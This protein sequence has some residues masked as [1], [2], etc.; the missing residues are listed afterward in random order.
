MVRYFERGAL[1]VLHLSA[2]PAGLPLDGPV[3]RAQARRLATIAIR[4][5]HRHTPALLLLTGGDTATEVLRGLKIANLRVV[6]E[7]LPGIPLTIAQAG[8]IHGMPVILK[9]GG[10]GDD[11]VLL[12]LVRLARV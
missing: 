2:P 3:A 10:F 6:R 9:P 8:R 4:Q 5:I 1:R 12:E 11:D 7:L